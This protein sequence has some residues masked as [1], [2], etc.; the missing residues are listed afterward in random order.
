M[1]KEDSFVLNKPDSKELI[2]DGTSKYPKRQLLSNLKVVLKAANGTVLYFRSALAKEK[3]L[4]L[5][6]HT[7]E[8]S[9]ICC[10]LLFAAN[11]NIDFLDEG[12]TWKVAG[13]I[14]EYAAQAGRRNQGSVTSRVGAAFSGSKVILRLHLIQKRLELIWGSRHKR[15]DVSDILIQTNWTVHTKFPS[16][17]AKAK[18][19]VPSLDYS[20]GLL[21]MDFYFPSPSLKLRFCGHLR[22]AMI[23]N[24]GIVKLRRSGLQLCGVKGRVLKIWCGTWNC[25]DTPSPGSLELSKWIDV[26][27]KYDV[28]AIGFQECDAKGFKQWVADCKGT[29]DSSG[30]AVDVVC[31]VS[32]WGIHL[33]VFVRRS[34]MQLVSNIR[35]DSVACGFANIAGNK[36]G[37]GCA[38]C[39]NES[40]ELAFISSHLAA[41]AKRVS[42]R[43]DDYKNIS[44]GMKGLLSHRGTDFLHQ[45]KHVFWLGDLNYRINLKDGINGRTGSTGMDTQGE[46]EEVLDIIA[47]KN[48]SYLHDHDQLN[49]QLNRNNGAFPYF[50][51]GALNFA[52]T[53]RMNKDK[54]GYSNKRFQSPSWT[55][56]I[57]VRTVCGYESNINQL[58]YTGHHDMMQSDHRPVSAQYAVTTGLPYINLS[59]SKSVVNR[60]RCDILFSDLKVELQDPEALAASIAAIEHRKGE[61]KTN[62][63]DSN[64]GLSRVQEDA[65][66]QED[67]DED[68][69]ETEGTKIPIDEHVRVESF[70]FDDPD[71]SSTRSRHSSLASTTSNST[72]GSA[73]PLPTTTSPE[74]KKKKK[75]KG[76]MSKLFGGTVK[77]GKKA[78][79]SIKSVPTA[80]TSDK[81]HSANKSA[82]SNQRKSQGSGNATGRNSVHGDEEKEKGK[83]LTEFNLRFTGDINFLAAPVSSE[84]ILVPNVND[85]EEG[86]TNMEIEWANELIPSIVPLAGDFS[87]VRAQNV[88]I[89]MRMR[90]EEDA[91]F[92]KIG[93]AEISLSAA[94]ADL[95][96]MAVR[97]GCGGGGE[98]GKQNAALRG[99]KNRGS[100]GGVEQKFDAPLIHRG[101]QV[102]YITGS[103]RLRNVVQ[104]ASSS[105]SKRWRRRSDMTFTSMTKKKFANMAEAPGRDSDP[106]DAPPQT[107]GRSGFNGGKK[108]VRNTSNGGAGGGGGGSTAATAMNGNASDNSRAKTSNSSGTGKFQAWG[109]MSG[110]LDDLDAWLEGD[111]N[112]DSDENPIEPLPVSTDDVLNK[113]RVVKKSFSMDPTSASIDP[114]I[115]SATLQRV[116]SFKQ[117]KKPR[118]L[119]GLT[120]TNDAEEE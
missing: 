76:L 34:I 104:P 93:C 11:K 111:D 91:A 118:P 23:P 10:R 2:N 18:I 43:C 90:R 61:E 78:M 31:S 36:G 60:D 79:T 112:S 67:E 49:Q 50:I 88:L 40:T 56:R 24:V 25:G 113:R 6:F 89:T 21:D 84:T 107:R 15:Y 52:P 45:L 22:A 62:P 71:D 115:R 73:A 7:T 109:G 44:A 42:E 82:K 3:E 110:N 80:T 87:Y 54:E 74:K 55:D 33:I 53:Y 85:F 14:V 38:F 4:A 103:V 75:K 77:M 81:N 59:V 117:N 26:Q 8:S 1:A 13:E 63:K 12:E 96:R 95:H 97:R 47:K 27:G 106:F 120:E 86:Q 70:G 119:A 58:G 99:R 37:V 16:N 114:L 94:T 9:D 32:L 102:G 108:Q 101:V 105:L 64:N 29:F 19:L 116:Q 35:T 20:S 17:P 48:L 51:E 92:H 83:H 65:E 28:Y 39:F 46:Y 66:E 5:D 98:G 41:R 68:E 57:L 69:D 30:F 100:Q 72:S